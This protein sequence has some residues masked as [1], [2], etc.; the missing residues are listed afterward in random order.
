MSFFDLIINKSVNDPEFLDGITTVV[1]T[2]FMTLLVIVI[3]I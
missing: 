2:G 3:L 1:L